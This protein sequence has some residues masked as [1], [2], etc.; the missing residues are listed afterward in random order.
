MIRFSLNGDKTVKMLKEE[1][2]TK[3]G[4]VLRVFN[5]NSEADGNLT[6]DEISNIAPLTDNGLIYYSKENQKVGEVIEEFMEFGG[7]KVKIATKDDWVLVLDEMPIF[8]VKDIPNNATRKIMEEIIAN[9]YIDILQSMQKTDVVYLPLGENGCLLDMEDLDHIA[10]AGW[11]MEKCVLGW[12]DD[13][14]F[15]DIL[16]EFSGKEFSAEV[17]KGLKD[18]L[19][20]TTDTLYVIAVLNGNIVCAES[21]VLKQWYPNLYSTICKTQS[22]PKHYIRINGIEYPR[23]SPDTRVADAWNEYASE[24][25]FTSPF[26]Q[27]EVS[28]NEFWLGKVDGEDDDEYT[29]YEKIAM[30]IIEDYMDSKQILLSALICGGYPEHWGKQHPDDAEISIIC[31][32]NVLFEGTNKE[33]CQ[34]YYGILIGDDANP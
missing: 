12:K 34:K 10:D 18:G 29:Q 16:I 2:Q 6:L 30:K 24:V 19:Y 11:Q 21:Y 9:P 5:G 32:D 22:A 4:G 1:F 17:Q 31:E 14:S 33:L 25:S 27:E 3:F 13:D 23:F 26:A 28:F 15:K 20:F 7:L 8:K